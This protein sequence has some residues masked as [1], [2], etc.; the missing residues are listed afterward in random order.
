MRHSCRSC[1]LLISVRARGSLHDCS[2]RAAILSL[3]WSPIGKCEKRRS[4]R[5]RSIPAF[6]SIASAAERTGLQDSSVDG[7]TVATAFH[8]FDQDKAKSE[9]R[10][11]LK[12]NAYCQMSQIFGK[13][14]TKLP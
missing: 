1:R 3:G 11:I 7:I 8:W 13:D 6:T 12:A 10:R 4:D 14:L 2:W 9:F 5:W